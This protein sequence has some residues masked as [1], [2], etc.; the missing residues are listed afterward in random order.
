MLFLP[1]VISHFSV[2]SRVLQLC[3]ANSPGHNTNL[4]LSEV[5]PEKKIS[6]LGTN[7]LVSL[8]ILVLPDQRSTAI[9]LAGIFVLIIFKKLII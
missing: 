9:S 6:L 2:D 3:T 8:V 7:Q 1:D 4:R 5:S